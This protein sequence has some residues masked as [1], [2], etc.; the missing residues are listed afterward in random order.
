MARTVPQT[1]VET[2][3]FADSAKAIFDEAE[4]IALIDHVARDPEVGTLIGGSGGLRYFR[5]GA[6]G[7]G[8][9]GGARIVYL[10]IGPQAPIYLLACYFKGRKQVFTPADKIAFRK[11]ADAIR[12]AHETHA[13]RR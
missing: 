4:R 9:S 2:G 3:S 5:W 11:V 12:T 7:H 13:R 6:K 10:F 8:K 1:V